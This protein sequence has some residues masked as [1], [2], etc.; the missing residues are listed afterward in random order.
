DFA[1]KPTLGRVV[2]RLPTK[3]LGKVVL[4]GEGVGSVVVVIVTFAVA[5]GLHQPGWRVEDVL[6]RKQ[7]ARLLGRAHGDTVSAIGGV[8]FRRGRD[9]DDGLRDRQLPFR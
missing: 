4:A 3:L 5:F 9:V 6:G 7:R 2:E 8:R 1:L